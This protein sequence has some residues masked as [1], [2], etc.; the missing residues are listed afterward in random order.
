MGNEHI[1]IQ[2]LENIEDLWGKKSLECV[3]IENFN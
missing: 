2:Q 3:W 1:I